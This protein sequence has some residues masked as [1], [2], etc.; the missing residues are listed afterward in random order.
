[1]E[2]E[3]ATRAHTTHVYCEELPAV[4]VFNELI[5]LLV[6]SAGLEHGLH[7]TL[8]TQ[9]HVLTSQLLVILQGKSDRAQDFQQMS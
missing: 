8:Q 7:E 2:E 3:R 4:N 6:V 1:M 5:E 9:T